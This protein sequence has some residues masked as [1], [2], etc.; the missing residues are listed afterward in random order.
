MDQFWDQNYISRSVRK[1]LT[2][3]SMRCAFKMFEI[4]YFGIYCWGIYKS[5][6]YLQKVK[7]RVWQISNLPPNVRNSSPRSGA[8]PPLPLM[9]SMM[10]TMMM[11]T[12]VMETMLVM[13]IQHKYIEEYGY[14]YISLIYAEL[15]FSLCCHA[16]SPPPWGWWWWPWWW[17]CDWHS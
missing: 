16:S 10:T 8:Q 11:V 9:I 7:D 2:F 15:I 4:W 6:V 1:M 13:M 5:Q 14:N 3:L 17:W 12:I